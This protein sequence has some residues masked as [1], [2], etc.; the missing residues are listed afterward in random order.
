MVAAGSVVGEWE[1]G[2]VVGMAVVRVEAM[3]GGA[4]RRGRRR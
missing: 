4:G 2:T 1:V 3:G